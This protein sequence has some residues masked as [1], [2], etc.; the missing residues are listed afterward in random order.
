M[1]YEQNPE[2]TLWKAILQ[3]GTLVEPGT[4]GSLKWDYTQDPGTASAG[5]PYCLNTRLTF[6]QTVDSPYGQMSFASLAAADGIIVPD[7][8]KALALMPDGTGVSYG[9]DYAYMRNLGERLVFRGGSWYN[10]GHAGVFC[11]DGNNPRSA[12]HTSIGFR[13]AFIPGI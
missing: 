2:S 10:G 5:I 9:G 7:R 6:Q 13:P 8:L 4:A 12:Y 1:Q 11:A 3:D